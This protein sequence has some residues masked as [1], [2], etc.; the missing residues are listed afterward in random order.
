MLRKVHK[1]RQTQSGDAGEQEEAD[2]DDRDRTTGEEQN[3]KHMQD[4]SIGGLLN[5]LKKLQ[6]QQSTFDLAC[7]IFAD[8]RVRQLGYM[9]LT[10]AIIG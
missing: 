1:F 9:L 6:K 5:Q 4:C 3:Q 8:D 10:W 7:S 2:E